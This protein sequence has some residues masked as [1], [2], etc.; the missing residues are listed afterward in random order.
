MR[1][2]AKPARQFALVD[3]ISSL[4]LIHMFSVVPPV[5]HG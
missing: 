5:W 4:W 1:V 2:L 3:S